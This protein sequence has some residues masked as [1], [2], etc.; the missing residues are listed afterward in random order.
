VVEVRDHEERCVAA[1][2]GRERLRHPHRKRH[3]HP[4]PDADHLHVGNRPELAQQRVQ[5]LVDQQQ[6][7]AARDQHVPHLAMGA[8]VL[9]AFRPGLT[10]QHRLPAP[11]DAAAG[12][13]AA[14]GRAAVER[15]EQHPVGILVD[16]RRN[17]PVR[18]LAERVAQLTRADPRLG[19]GGDRLHPHRTERVLAVDQ[20]QVVRRDAQPEHLPRLLA[21]APLVVGQ[22]HQ[23]R[24]LLQRAN[25]VAHLPAP[26]AP[27][28]LAR[29][30][31]EAAPVLDLHRVLAAQARA[32]WRH[33]S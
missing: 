3:R 23:A 32:C 26:V 27:L 5:P 7:I 4:S 25:G 30:G 33:H 12:A 6:R 8:H 24:E 9:D 19:P 1:K 10:A 22:R 17:W 21:P 28:L 20:R 11:R 14:V 29:L 13:V 18:I 2:Q 16:D 31:K 15:E